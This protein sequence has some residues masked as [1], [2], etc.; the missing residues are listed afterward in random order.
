MID[1]SIAPSPTEKTSFEIPKIQKL[2]LSNGIEIYFVPKNNLPV[3][4]ISLLTEAGSKYDPKGKKGLSYLTSLL[5]DEG[6]AKF[7]AIELSDEFEKLGSMFSVS[8]D[9][10]HVNL[11]L[12][13]LRENFDRSLY[14][15][16][17]ILTEPK[18]EQK[19]FVREKKKVLDRILQ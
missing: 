12:L 7:D 16:G 3:V 4:Y 11:S 1:R 17:K 13:S 14:L 10:D 15:L 8:C 19:D 18:F 9:Q 6:A 2:E 5:I